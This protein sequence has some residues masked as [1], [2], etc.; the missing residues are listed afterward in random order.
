[1]RGWETTW[2][3]G[4][5]TM[6]AAANVDLVAPTTCLS[7]LPWTA[8]KLTWTGAVPRGFEVGAIR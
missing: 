3:G 6:V 2:E 1:M 4:P 7:V 5:D 8:E